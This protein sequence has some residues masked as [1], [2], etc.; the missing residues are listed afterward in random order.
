MPLGCCAEMLLQIDW[1]GKALLLDPAS[2][3]QGV[4]WH[5]WQGTSPYNVLN[6]TAVTWPRVAG[7]TKNAAE[8]L[9][10]GTEPSALNAEYSAGRMH[11]GVW[12]GPSLGDGAL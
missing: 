5:P 8:H 9:I 2:V 4:L 7:D 12:K 1:R 11:K 6:N 10:R 3:P